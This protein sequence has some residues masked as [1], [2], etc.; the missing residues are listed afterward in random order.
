KF[1]IAGAGTEGRTHVRIFA[2][3]SRGVNLLYN[4]VSGIRRRTPPRPAK[5]V[6][7]G[8]VPLCLELDSTSLYEEQVSERRRGHGGGPFIAQV[9]QGLTA[10]V[11]SL[12]PSGV[13]PDAAS[14]RSMGRTGPRRCPH[15]PP[16]P[17]GTPQPFRCADSTRS[18]SP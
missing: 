5:W 3:P 8:S 14:Q 6:R 1:V 15:R 12:A 18:L 2:P 10:W 16:H 7:V 9:D 4:D 17:A 13:E 11:S